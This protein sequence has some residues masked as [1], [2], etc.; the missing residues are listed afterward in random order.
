MSYGFDDSDETI[1]LP[2]VSKNKPQKKQPPAPT[3]KAK[4]EQT[5]ER[6]GFVSRR[7][8]KRR[9]PGPRRT[10]EQDKLTLTGPKR[11]LDLLRQKSEE[12]DG[13]PYWQVLEKHLAD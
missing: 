1:E 12:M 9:R 8:T 2:S 11:V 13:A 6:L 10:E 3:D 7:V 5:G 4:L